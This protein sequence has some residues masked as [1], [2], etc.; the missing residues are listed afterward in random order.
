[1]AP[2]GDAG[3]QFDE[4][5]ALGESREL[6]RQ[7]AA[8][9]QGEGGAV[10]HQFVL[11]PHHVGV[12][13]G[14]AALGHPRPGRVDAL[15]LLVHV[16]GGGVQR[17]QRLGARVPG[18]DGGAGF[19]DVGA[20]A[21]AEADAG[22]LEHA[23]IEAGREGADFIEHRMVG[24]DLLAIDRD[25]RAV[26]QHRRGVVAF[27]AFLEGVAHHRGQPRGQPV[28]QG[29]EDARVLV[30]EVVAQGQVLRRIAAQG[31]FRGDEQGGAGF[32]GLKGQVGDA[33]GVAFQVA[34]HG[35]HLG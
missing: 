13:Q 27:L 18:H 29:G 8:G 4:V 35:V 17:Q 7:P 12:D 10:E 2:L 1:M 5:E 25:D 21:D 6:G 26:P 3:V 30:I 9:I 31:E 16:E 11:A 15:V 23:G 14:Q 22:A 32:G 19:P 34:D 28:R 24:Q 20:D 33:F